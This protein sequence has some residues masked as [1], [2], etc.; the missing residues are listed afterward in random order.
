LDTQ[1]RETGLRTVFQKEPRDVIEERIR[2]SREP[3]QRNFGKNY[4]R[5][6]YYTE[7]LDIPRRPK[8]YNDDDKETLESRERVMFKKYLER[9]YNDY[10]ADRLNYFEHNLDVW[11]QLWRTCEISDI[12]LVLADI[13]HPKFHF[14]PSLYRYIVNDLKKPFILVLTKCDLVPEENIQIWIDYFTTNYPGI[15]IAP[16]RSFVQT[17]TAV[18][19]A[20]KRRIARRKYSPWGATKLLA[21]CQE[22]AVEISTSKIQFINE[23]DL[24]DS[25]NEDEKDQENEQDDNNQEENP[26]AEV[27]E[28]DLVL[29]EEGVE[30]LVQTYE[31]AYFGEEAENDFITLGLIG[32]PNV[33]KSTL[34]NAL[35]GKT[36]CSTSRTP[37]HTKYR[38]TI[39]LSPHLRLCDCPGLIFPAVDMPRQLQ[40]LTGLYPIAQTREPYSCVGFIA[41]RVPLEDIYGLKNTFDEP[42]S[43]WYM[44]EAYAEKKK[45]YTKNGRPDVYRA[46]NEIL[47]DHCDGKVVLYYLPDTNDVGIIQQPDEDVNA[48]TNEHFDI[49]KKSHF[50]TESSSESSEEVQH[51]PRSNPFELLMDD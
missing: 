48:P 34:I 41:E 19:G 1:N 45:Y 11:R 44:A 12:L 35:V 27:D 24:E 15:R 51:N 10:G 8:W 3:L 43:G 37:G 33:G 4:D 36:V 30:S 38:Q 39:F 49:D 50:K 22:I 25:A 2:M 20:K 26:D 32:H 47:R 28:E 17:Q 21:L 16:V 6:E 14:P 23:L 9:L 42:W 13:R 5:A 7:L 46:G 29:P 18:I 40:V 31:D